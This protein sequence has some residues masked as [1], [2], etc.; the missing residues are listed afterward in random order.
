M[1]T[2][3]YEPGKDSD[4]LRRCQSGDERAWEALTRRYER[5]I[6][7][8]ALR[9]GLNEEDAADVFQFV[10]LRLLDNFDRVR[11]ED[12]L[13]PWLITTAK[14]EAWRIL[15]RRRRQVEWTDD[16]RRAHEETAAAVDDPLPEEV[17]LQ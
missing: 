11:G 4:L 17:L 8:V 2:R 6:Y 3:D 10:C 12:H 14:R 13:T 15:R 9:C 1:A 7:S 16:E 5:L